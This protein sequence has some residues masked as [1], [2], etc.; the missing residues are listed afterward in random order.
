MIFKKELNK[1]MPGEMYQIMPATDV[2]ELCDK[3]RLVVIIAR[4]K[5]ISEADAIE[6]LKKS[7]FD[8]PFEY[9]GEYFAYSED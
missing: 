9:E 6:L 5:D 8:E 2:L 1:L 4:Q 7:S 3:Q